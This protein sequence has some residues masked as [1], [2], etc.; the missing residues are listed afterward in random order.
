VKIDDAGTD[1]APETPK[2]GQP[3]ITIIPKRATKSGSALADDSV[4]APE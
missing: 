1:K 4:N 3:N 2:Q